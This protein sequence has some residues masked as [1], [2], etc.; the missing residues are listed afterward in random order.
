MGRSE[1]EVTV[2]SFCPHDEQPGALCPQC[3]TLISMAL[4]VLDRCDRREIAA[5]ADDYALRILDDLPNV[6][7]EAGASRRPGRCASSASWPRPILTAHNMPAR[8]RLVSACHRPGALAAQP[9][10]RHR[11][12]V[13]STSASALQPLAGP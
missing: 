8:E 11:T 10:R 5:L 7:S 9:A 4:G 12:Q 2:T 3:V 13:P 1:G 6:E